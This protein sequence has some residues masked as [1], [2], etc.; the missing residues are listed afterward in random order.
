MTRRG[1]RCLSTAAPRNSSRRYSLSGTLTIA[2]LLLWVALVATSRLLHETADLEYLVHALGYPLV[3][4][5][6]PFDPHVVRAVSLMTAN[7]FLIGF[8]L[9]GAVHLAFDRRFRLRAAIAV[10]TV[11]GICIYELTCD[12][13]SS[14]ITA[15]VSAVILLRLAISG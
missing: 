11:A 14:A 1:E 7:S 4:L 2:H 13:G 12:G 8:A 10:A 9:A 6:A 15:G 3:V 5:T